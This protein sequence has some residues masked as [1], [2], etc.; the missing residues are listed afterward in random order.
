MNYRE[1]IFS[2]AAE[3]NGL[4]ESSWCVKENIPT[5]YLSRM[6]EAGELYRIDR[7]IYSVNKSGYDQYYFFQQRNK[8]AVFSFVSALYLQGETDIIPDSLEVT[9]YTGYNAGHFPE[10]TIV[11]YVPKE[12]LRLGKITVQTPMGNEVSCYD[13]ERTV[14]DV[15]SNRSKVDGEFFS[16]TVQSYA[17]GNKKDLARLFTYAKQMN[18]LQRVQEIM[19]VLL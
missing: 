1:A 17:R 9:V 5:T 4:V 14:C 11:H 10:S 3:N 15:I 19:E 2:Y 18:C 13:Y 7:G 8:V 16:K 12:I 6:I